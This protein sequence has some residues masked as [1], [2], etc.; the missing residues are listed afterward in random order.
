M[1]IVKRP[2]KKDGHRTLIGMIFFVLITLGLSTINLNN[3]F[4]NTK[5]L[6]ARSEE[7]SVKTSTASFWTDFLS[8]HPDYIEGWIELERYDKAAEINPNYLK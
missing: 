3:Y 7:T 6:G 1:Q 8:K 2:A 4:S 5:V